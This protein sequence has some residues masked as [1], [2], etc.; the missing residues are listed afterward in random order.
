MG[1]NDASSFSRRFSLHIDIYFLGDRY[2]RKDK[3]LQIINQPAIMDD[4]MTLHDFKRWKVDA[5]D[6]WQ[7]GDL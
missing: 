6:E 5:L 7:Q 4:N 1:E 3:T 2:L